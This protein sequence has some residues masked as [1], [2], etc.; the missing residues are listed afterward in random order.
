MRSLYADFGFLPVSPSSFSWVISKTII[1][2]AVSAFQREDVYPALRVDASDVNGIAIII[3]FNP[4]RVDSKPLLHHRQTDG[5][6]KH[7]DFR[8]IKGG[9]DMLTK[10]ANIPPRCFRMD[11]RKGRAGATS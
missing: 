7:E 4:P 9:T 11:F 10:P 8:S 3:A 1:R 5:I 6:Q 2:F